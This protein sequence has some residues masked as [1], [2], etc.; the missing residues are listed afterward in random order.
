VI[1]VVLEEVYSIAPDGSDRELQFRSPRP[2]FAGDR[3]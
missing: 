1:F 3:L 2:L